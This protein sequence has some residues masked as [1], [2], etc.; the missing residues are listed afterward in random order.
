MEAQRWDAFLDWL[1]DKGLLTR[2]MPSRQP[3]EGQ[4][5]S[6]DDLRQGRGGERIPRDAVKS[7]DMFTNLFLPQG[8]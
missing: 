1:A 8:P 2:A 6:L 3:V 7:A 4:S 5:A